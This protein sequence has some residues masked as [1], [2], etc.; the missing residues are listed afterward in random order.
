MKKL[1]SLTLFNEKKLNK[2]QKSQ[3]LGGAAIATGA[4]TRCTAATATGCQSYASDKSEGSVTTFYAP[5]GETSQ[6]C[7]PT[8]P[9]TGVGGQ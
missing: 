9:A 8:A 5:F 2:T 4:G 3:I 1:E 6:Q 7:S